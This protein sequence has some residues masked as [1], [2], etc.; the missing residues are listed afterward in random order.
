M[1]S[2][3]TIPS[4]VLVLVAVVALVAGNRELV[5]GWLR[6]AWGWVRPAPPSPSPMPTPSDADILARLIA[7]REDLI[8]AGETDVAED[9]GHAITKVLDL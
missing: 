2:L 9:V 3:D 1:P 7:I 6:A 5:W 4:W 8:A